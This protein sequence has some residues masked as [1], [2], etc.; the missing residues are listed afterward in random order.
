MQRDAITLDFG[1]VPI[2]TTAL[3]DMPISVDAG[4]S[5]FSVQINGG[6]A[7]GFDFGD[8]SGTG[9]T[10]CTAQTSFTPTDPGLINTFYL[11][12][13]CP[14]VGGGCLLAE[15]TV[16]ANAVAEPA[17]IPAPASAALVA[18]GLFGLATMRRRENLPRFNSRHPATGSAREPSR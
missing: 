5:V 3:L 14:V 2:G 17:A 13:A 4:F 8:C 16:I 11:L 6:L 7:F 10:A 18:L 15:Y 12:G 9:I 1:D